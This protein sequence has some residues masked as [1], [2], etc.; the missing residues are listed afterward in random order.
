MQ[1]Q[2][3]ILHTSQNA[4]ADTKIRTRVESVSSPHIPGLAGVGLRVGY[5]PTVNIGKRL[6]SIYDCCLLHNN[7]APAIARGV[8]SDVYADPTDQRGA[9]DCALLKA[10]GKALNDLD[11]TG[12]KALL[13]LPIHF[14]TLAVRRWRLQFVAILKALPDIASRRLLLDIEGIEPGTPNSRLRQLFTV[15]HPLV[16]GMTWQVSLNWRSVEATETMHV[17]GLSL[18][19]DEVSDARQLS[20][21]VSFAHHHGFR[22]FLRNVGDRQL[23]RIARKLGVDYFNGD[24]LAQPQ[25]SPGRAYLL[26]FA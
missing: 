3:K 19:A 4:I 26:P 9:I 2:E 15:V 13:S 17:L 21:F 7:N 12:R 5:R 20:A 22:V 16:L 1:G 24:S 10:A 23:A 14:D 25:I 6:V 8:D 18:Q 11:G